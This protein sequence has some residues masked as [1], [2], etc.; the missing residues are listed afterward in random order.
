MAGI[1]KGM[2]LLESNYLSWV[3]FYTEKNE[4]EPDPTPYRTEKTKMAAWLETVD[5]AANTTMPANRPLTA[6]V[7]NL[8]PIS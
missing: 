2:L 6:K 5:Q 3:K 7:L 8:F 4:N 1:A